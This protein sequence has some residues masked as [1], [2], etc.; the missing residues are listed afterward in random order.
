MREP[1]DICVID[2]QLHPDPGARRPLLTIVH[3]TGTIITGSCALNML[4]GL[5]YDSSSSDLNLI[6]P[7]HKFVAMD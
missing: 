1:R 7:Q 4:L 5:S 2:R 6:V 3:Q